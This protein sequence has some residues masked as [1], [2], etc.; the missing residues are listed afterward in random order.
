MA[1]KTN[2]GWT[3]EFPR[4]DVTVDIQLYGNVRQ[5]TDD[6]GKQ[7]GQSSVHGITPALK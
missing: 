3:W 5:Y 7:Q 6:K 2:I 1:I 4:Y